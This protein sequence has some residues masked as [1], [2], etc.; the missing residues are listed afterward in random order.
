MIRNT[1]LYNITFIILG[2]IC[3]IFIALLM[4]E[5]I[6][7]S[8]SKIFQAGL[9]L[10]N[11]ISMVIVSYIVYVFLNADSGFI[12]LSILRPLELPEISWYSEPHYWPYILVIVQLWKTAGFNFIIYIASIAGIDKGIYEAAKIDG[13]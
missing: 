10:P 12:N 6:D 13:G 8:Y 5:L 11:L 3:S 9:V 4:S 2:T 1:L 7:A